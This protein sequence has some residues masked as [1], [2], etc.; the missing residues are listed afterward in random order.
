M[1]GKW[2]LCLFEASPILQLDVT[3]PMLSG[4]YQQCKKWS[5]VLGDLCYVMLCELM[6]T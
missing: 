5:L 1:V 3:Y 4:T 2:I 6:S